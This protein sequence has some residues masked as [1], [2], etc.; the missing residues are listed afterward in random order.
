MEGELFCSL[1]TASYR[2]D[3]LGCCLL[4][5]MYRDWRTSPSKLDVTRNSTEEGNARDYF[6]T[7]ALLLALMASDVSP[8]RWEMS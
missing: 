8:G 5:F 3:R 7:G 1:V 2:M 4:W 6:Y